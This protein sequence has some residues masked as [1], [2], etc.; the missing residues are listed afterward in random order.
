MK[1]VLKNWY[2]N[3]GGS[4]PSYSSEFQAI[5]D[6]ATT[7][8]YTHTSYLSQTD[9]FISGMVSDGDWAE[10]DI[11]YILATDQADFSRINI[12]T[13]ASFL[14]TAG[15]TGA[16]HTDKL[17]WTSGGAGYLDTTYNP[18]SDGVKY[19]LNDAS[20]HI[21][22]TAAPTLG[23]QSVFGNRNSTSG[24]ASRIFSSS[25][26]CLFNSASTSSF[27]GG[28][29]FTTGLYSFIRSAS[30]LTSAYKDGVLI[31]TSAAASSAIASFV[32]YILALNNNGAALGFTDAKIGF[33]LVG[34]KNISVTNL[35]S[36]WNTYQAAIA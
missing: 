30:N 5:L 34:S 9:A 24:V 32:F 4:Y 16:A 15:G 1:T 17:G 3:S 28:A 10:A 23:S 8:G 14:A 18:A 31:N 20:I 26:S 2:L 19:L 7:R 36:R 33:V 6:N 13:P 29:T 25:A 11:G 27:P 35:T 21:G 22:I 12:K